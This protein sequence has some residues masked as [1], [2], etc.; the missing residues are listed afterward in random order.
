MVGAA[1]AAM[2]FER[3]TA[4]KTEALTTSKGKRAGIA[5]AVMV[6]S[7]AFVALSA[8]K[9]VGWREKQGVHVESGTVT[10]TDNVFQSD[11]SEFYKTGAGTYVLPGAKF[12]QRRPPNFVVADGTLKFQAGEDA[13]VDVATP[14]A[15]LQ[16]AAFWVDAGRNVVTEESDGAT[17]VTRW[18]DV[19]E[20]DTAT[21]TM[22]Y[23]VP[24]WNASKDEGFAT[25]LSVKPA[26]VTKDGVQSVYFGGAKSGQ[27]MN[28]VTS[29]GADRTLSHVKH[30]FVV[31]GVYECF[32]AVIGGRAS[33][34]GIWIKW[35]RAG[36]VT[37]AQLRSSKSHSVNYRS[38]MAPQMMS[39]RWYLDG[40][41]FD[42]LREPPD[43][44]KFQLLAMDSLTTEMPVSCFYNEMGLNIENGKATTRGGDYLA[45][46]VFFERKLS[47][48][49]RISVERYLMKKWNLG[50]DKLALGQLPVNPAAPDGATTTTN[51][52]WTTR[53]T[54]N[55]AIAKD[56]TFAVETPAGTRSPLV[57]LSGE[58][59]V[60]KTG[61]GSLQIGPQKGSPFTGA[62]DLQEGV[63]D[64]RGGAYPALKAVAGRKVTGTASGNQSIFRA[65]TNQFE[66]SARYAVQAGNAGEF[67]KAGLEPLAVST[68][69]AAVKKLS[70]LKGQLQL[71]CPRNVAA[72]DNSKAFAAT[73]LQVRIADP[74]FE[75]VTVTNG[76]YYT[77]SASAGD[78]DGWTPTGTGVNYIL[79]VS[80][81][82]VLPNY[83]TSQWDF[84][85]NRRPVEGNNCIK[86]ATQW[87]QPTLSQQLSF[88]T[89]GRYR[90]SFYMTGMVNGGWSFK[91]QPLCIQLDGV[92]VGYAF[93]G[94]YDWLRTYVNLGEVSAGPHTLTFS[95]NPKRTLSLIALDDV[96]IDFDGGKQAVTADYPIPNG[97]FEE[98]V[99]EYA[100][101]LATNY[102]YA[103]DYNHAKGWTCTATNTPAHPGVFPAFVATD[104]TRMTSKSGD[105][106][107]FS[108]TRLLSVRSSDKTGCSYLAFAGSAGRASTTFEAPQGIWYLKA[109]VAH[110]KGYFAGPSYGSDFKLQAKITRADSSVVDLGTVTA[111]GCVFDEVVWPTGLTF[112]APEN[113]TLTLIP[114]NASIGVVDDLRLGF[115][116]VNLVQNGSFEY[117]T[118]WS[119]CADKSVY[120]NSGAS[121]LD[122]CSSSQWQGAN[123]GF[124][125]HDGKYVGQIMT[126]ATFYQD[127][128]FPESGYYRLS[129]AIRSRVGVNNYGKNV[130]TFW[131][132]GDDMGAITTNKIVQVQPDTLNFVE[133]SYLFYVPTKGVRRFGISGEGCPGVGIGSWTENTSAIDSV[134]IVRALDVDANAVPSAPK[135][136][137][138]SVDT[139]ATLNLDFPGT[140]TCGPVT[141]GGTTVYGLVNAQTYP[142]YVT[143]VGS[144]QAN[145]PG[146]MIIFR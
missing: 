115:A 69:D 122:T 132:G 90:L 103:G 7:C 32:G 11:N 116:G 100:G 101:V 91:Q 13:T 41:A 29:A 86:L 36:L 121:R 87:G 128:Y 34:H 146:A 137:R 5:V 44:G 61:S 76:D 55:V 125:G 82:Q 20:T 51:G 19:R 42:I 30:A 142:Q 48:A 40:R 133:H 57:S 54:G 131:E 81:G 56:A 75:H 8:D 92:T 123:K 134:S 46:A 31:H 39:S 67:A 112:T 73:N 113:V 33:G 66:S 85:I 47:E 84:W 58:G 2:R 94:V 12:N 10:E 49:E 68:V 111:R 35:D 26:Y 135:K 72:V 110:D 17:R 144:L 15:V 59:T 129:F 18:C 126:T 21:P 119:S 141:L 80:D 93:T 50:A 23:A 24:A 62:I 53:F 120:V 97:D 14:P 60:V 145:N 117:D 37:E 130:L 43:I 63:I 138:I 71:T 143:G 139:G 114:L 108:A 38:D 99:T 79:A 45:E 95:Y 6:L 16:D 89:T 4:M 98:W 52:L 77:H 107:A 28:F 83:T 118:D 124:C 3:N 105:N 88:P 1:V 70:V 9:V 25:M 102:P 104:G 127:I 22:G 140:L 78:L 136:M 74:G 65:P 96:R 106:Y 109:K 27:Y 64:V